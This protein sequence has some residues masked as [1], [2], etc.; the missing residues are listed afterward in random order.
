MYQYWDTNGHWNVIIQTMIQAHYGA[1]GLKA[2]CIKAFWA[3]G[4]FLFS[5]PIEIVEDEAQTPKV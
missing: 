1:S 5:F 4:S 2:A 3:G